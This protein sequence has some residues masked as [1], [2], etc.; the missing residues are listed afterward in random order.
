MK[1]ETISS[2][3]DKFILKLDAQAQAR[4]LRCLD[5]LE[6]YEYKLGMPYSKSLKGGLFELRIVGNK[7]IRIIY[8]FH[9]GKIYLLNA[10]MKKTNKIPK[11]EFDLAIKRFK[12]FA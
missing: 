2:D 5:L 12:M 7:H 8:C 10:F 11:K 1:T 9:D 3:I 4:V 6:K